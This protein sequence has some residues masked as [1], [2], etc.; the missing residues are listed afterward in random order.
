M[1]ILMQCSLPSTSE[2]EKEEE[3][4][5]IKD[6]NEGGTSL[7][8]RQPTKDNYNWQG[9]NRN[10]TIKDFVV[11]SVIIE[12]NDLNLIGTKFLFKRDVHYPN[13]LE[14][15]QETPIQTLSPSLREIAMSLQHDPS[16]TV[17]DGAKHFRNLNQRICEKMFKTGSKTHVLFNGQA[18]S[19]IYRCNISQNASTTPEPETDNEDVFNEKNVSVSIIESEISTGPFLENPKA[20]TE[21]ANTPASSQLSL[22][23]RFGHL[24]IF[25]QRS[26]SGKDLEDITRS[27]INGMLEKCIE[28]LH[29]PVVNSRLSGRSTHTIVCNMDTTSPVSEM[30]RSSMHEMSHL[31]NELERK[32]STEKKDLER[33]NDHQFSHGDGEVLEP[34]A[35]GIRQSAEHIRFLRRQR[36]ERL[37]QLRDE[38]GQKKGGRMELENGSK[39]KN[40]METNTKMEKEEVRNR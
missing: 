37:K 12:E 9:R 40:E 5:R 19:E 34:S 36:M 31:Q 27:A 1:R 25:A 6:K 4:R 28:N 11:S 7:V 8:L 24:S 30:R 29:K 10:N 35:D 14:V 26:S 2:G 17:T 32:I 15:L 39:L 33:E 20:A 22:E 13:R 18:V 3:E 23:D 21:E 38:L 16:S